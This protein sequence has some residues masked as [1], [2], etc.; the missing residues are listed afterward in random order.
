MGTLFDRI[1]EAV[2]AGRYI[3]SDHADD[4]LRE[5]WMKDWY[6]IAGL[7]EGKL[8]HEDPSAMPNPKVEVEQVLP[9][10]TPIKAVWSWLEYNQSARLVTVHHFDQ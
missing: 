5:R 8:I 6:V 4:Q 7:T 3:I 9:D 10:G 1:R 2:D